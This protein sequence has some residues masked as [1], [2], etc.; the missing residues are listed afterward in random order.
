[1]AMGYGERMQYYMHNFLR[2]QPDLNFHNMD[3]QDALLDV[4]HFW[5]QRGVDGFRLD[6]VNFYLHDSRTQRQPGALERRGHGNDRR[7]P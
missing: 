4:A 7:R 2:E 5:L 1:M 6:T 3:V